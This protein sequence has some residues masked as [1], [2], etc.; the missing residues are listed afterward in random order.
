LDSSLG[1]WSVHPAF[2]GM[3]RTDPYRSRTESQARTLSFPD[4][5]ANA[6]ADPHSDSFA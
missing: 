2:S 6:D 5:N 4:P 1:G 3:P